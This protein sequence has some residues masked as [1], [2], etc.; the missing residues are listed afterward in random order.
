MDQY[1]GT[2]SALFAFIW[3]RR[4]L[5]VQHASTLLQQQGVLFS[6]EFALIVS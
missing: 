2:L 3:I 4:I 5:S 6:R 1:S